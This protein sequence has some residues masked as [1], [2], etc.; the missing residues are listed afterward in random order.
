MMSRMFFCLLFTL[1]L[2]ACSDEKVES[3]MA[4]S[5]E[6]LLLQEIEQKQDSIALALFTAD[7]LLKE[8]ARVKDSILT[9][10]NPKVLSYQGR[11][12]DETNQQVSGFIPLSDEF[13][14]RWTEHPDSLIIESEYLEKENSKR[15]YHVLSP[16]K[17]SL[18]L[19]LTDISESDSLFIYSLAQ[20]SIIRF[21]VEDVPIIA[22]INQYGSQGPPYQQEF[23]FGFEFESNPFNELGHSYIY[24][25]TCKINPFVKG[26]I[27][28]IEWQEMDPLK[29][30]EA[31]ISNRDSSYMAYS[32]STNC[33]HF[34]D[35]DFEYMLQNWGSGT[36]PSARRVLV[37]SIESGEVM[38]NTMFHD[39]EGTSIIPLNNDENADWGFPAQQTGRLF[40]N[41]PPVIFGFESYSFGCGGLGY[42]SPE[43]GWLR[44]HCDNR[45]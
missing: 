30:P 42:I 29:F 32:H 14:F 39:S 10:F 15:N 3:N 37:L 5:E 27:K 23:Q 25:T 16:K 17:R 1:C 40:K 11:W 33:F 12:D 35:E 9:A 7:S 8:Q 34:I 24:A 6:E 21:K 26:G 43:G 20:D 19:E 13:L 36:F 41:K 22:M 4:T 28:A 45:H 18:V 2:M 44:I 38:F 31:P